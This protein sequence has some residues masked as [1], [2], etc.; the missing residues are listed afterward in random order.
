MLGVRETGVREPGRAMMR[1]PREGAVWPAKPNIKPHGL[2][3]DGT[4]WK[5]PANGGVDILRA[6]ETRVGGLGGPRCDYRCPCSSFI[7]TL[8]SYYPLSYKT[9]AKL[10]YAYKTAVTGSFKKPLR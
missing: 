4:G 2:D 10:L 9:P 3:I 7:K 5:P 8:I 1:L 6:R